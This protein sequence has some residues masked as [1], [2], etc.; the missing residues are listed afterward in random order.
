MGGYRRFIRV[1]LPPRN[2][3]LFYIVIS[4]I[5]HSIFPEAKYGSFLAGMSFLV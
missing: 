5:M 2:H 3:F 1:V 4:K